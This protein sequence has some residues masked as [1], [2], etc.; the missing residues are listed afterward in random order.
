MAWYEP[1]AERAPDVV[2][3]WLGIEE[4]RFLSVRREVRRRGGAG[5]AARLVPQLA[6]LAD[7]LSLIVREL[8]EAAFRAPGGEEDWNVAQA[9]GHDADARAGLAMAGSLAAQGRFPPDTAA[10]VPG[11]AGP[12][13]ATR[14]ALIR[15]IEVS[16]KIVERA[17]RSIAGHET[18]PCPLVHP[19]VGKLRCGEWLLFA[20]VH[21]LMHLEQLHKLSDSFAAA[22]A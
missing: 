10:V 19:W 12:P 22:R 13:D 4:E 5:S 8:P 3:A 15:R 16:Q 1:L 18:E 17:A 20:G 9:I 6:S 21:D 2:A 11:V 14:E 7:A